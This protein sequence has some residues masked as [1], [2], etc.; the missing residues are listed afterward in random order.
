MCFEALA[1]VSFVPA[2]Q[3][4]LFMPGQFSGGSAKLAE[5]SHV[6]V[7]LQSTAIPPLTQKGSH[8]SHGHM[9]FG[10]VVMYGVS[11]TKCTEPHSNL[12]SEVRATAVFVRHH[13]HTSIPPILQVV[14]C[15]TEHTNAKKTR[16]WLMI[17]FSN[18]GVGYLHRIDSYNCYS[19]QQ[20][21]TPT[22]N[23]PT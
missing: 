22:S 6:C 14:T 19:P 1:E 20:W 4:L 13:P 17:Q 9:G 5:W 10:D 23:H 2:W 7:K 3:S 16:I 12:A 8:W 11:T 15:K 18:Y 21:D